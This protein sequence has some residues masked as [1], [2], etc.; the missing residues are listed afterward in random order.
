MLYKI[1]YPV[2]TIKNLYMARRMI[3]SPVKHGDI[4]SFW[5]IRFSWNHL[6]TMA[7]EKWPVVAG[8][9]GRWPIGRF[10]TGSF[11]GLA[12]GGSAVVGGVKVRMR[13]EPGD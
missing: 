11:H 9:A 6:G 4:P 7:Q 10:N 3:F 12:H 13:I 1:R 2:L 5:L 8:I